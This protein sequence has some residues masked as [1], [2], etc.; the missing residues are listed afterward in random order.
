MCAKNLSAVNCVKCEMLV[1]KSCCNDTGYIKYMYG[2]IWCNKGGGD[3]RMWSRCVASGVW[4]WKQNKSWEDAVLEALSSSSLTSC[5]QIY[6]FP[7]VLFIFKAYIEVYAK[8]AVSPI[9]HATR[10]LKY[11]TE[12]KVLLLSIN[13]YLTKTYS[14]M[15]T[16]EADDS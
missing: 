12:V 13:H 9:W 6:R 11:Y 16:L 7:L 3:Q 4:M 10:I 15:S 5:D 1:C 14:C 8:V 2:G